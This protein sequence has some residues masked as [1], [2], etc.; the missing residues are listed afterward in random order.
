MI[1]NSG[2]EYTEHEN[3]TRNQKDVLLQLHNRENF[4]YNLKKIKH[5]LSLS[6]NASVIRAIKA[7]QS[8]GLVD[9]LGFPILGRVHIECSG[10]SHQGVESI[11]IY[12]NNNFDPME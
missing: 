5:N 6:H 10:T 3:L 12:Q 11:I 9:E 1:M 2:S 4:K 7:L 8:K